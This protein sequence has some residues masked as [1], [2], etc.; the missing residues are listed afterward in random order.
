MR[1]TRR[2][3]QDGFALPVALMAIV[4]IGALIAGAFFASTQESRVGRN[5]LAEQRAF[6][7]A[8]NGLAIVADTL[9]TMYLTSGMVVGTPRTTVIPLTDATGGTGHTAVDSVRVTKLSS[10]LVLVTSLG[11]L[12]SGAAKRHTSMVLRFALPSFTMPGALTVSGGLTIGG[13]SQISGFDV[14]PPGWD[15]TLC[16]PNDGG[17]AGIATEPGVTIRINGAGCEGL[18]CVSAPPSVP[19]QLETAAAGDTATFFVYGNTTWNDLVRSATIS[20]V[21][22]TYH[23]FPDSLAAVAPSAAGRCNTIGLRGPMNWGEPI[24]SGAGSVRPCTSRYPIV[25]FD[26]NAR[27]NAGSRGQ[28]IL[29]V[30][31]DLTLSG[32]FE[33]AGPIILRGDLKTTGSNII[34]GSVSAAN[35]DLDRETSVASGNPTI[36]YS[37]CA[38]QTAISSAIKP[39]PLINRS[40]VEMFQ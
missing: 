25:Y 17:K 4:V 20:L 11:A 10:D 16:P 23:P 31:G 22:G 36:N 38:I 1:I 7:A 5:S 19:K 21:A 27:L 35:V 13:A 2:L 8:E 18:A 3:K 15:A 26:G 6:A 24:H 34:R 28:G 32:G 37:N 40:W 14:P 30:N 29:L 12:N 39:T 33:W 9:S